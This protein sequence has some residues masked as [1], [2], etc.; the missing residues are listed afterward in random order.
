MNWPLERLA[1]SFWLLAFGLSLNF[2]NI[3]IPLTCLTCIIY[4]QK[5]QLLKANSQQPASNQS[6]QIPTRK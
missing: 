5:S 6:P 4:I 2:Q 3:P 1:F